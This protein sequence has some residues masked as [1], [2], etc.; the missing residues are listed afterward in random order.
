MVLTTYASNITIVD[1]SEI[2]HEFDVEVHI[3][4]YLFLGYD[5]Y[6]PGGFLGSDFRSF[7]SN[8]RPK[9]HFNF[10][11]LCANWLVNLLGGS[12]QDL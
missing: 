4:R 3:W 2:L 6:I 11:T 7:N 5:I 12:S 9:K 8:P 1:A 10:N